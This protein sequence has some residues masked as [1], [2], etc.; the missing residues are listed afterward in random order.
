M[1]G[2]G[3]G[4]ETGGHITECQEHGGGGGATSVSAT[5]NVT[6]VQVTGQATCGLWPDAPKPGQL[7]G[8]NFHLSPCFLWL[9]KPF[10]LSSLRGEAGDTALSRPDVGVWCHWDRTHP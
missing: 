10:C 2:V 5:G 8:K 6:L 3:C 4:F 1:I 9:S 7:L